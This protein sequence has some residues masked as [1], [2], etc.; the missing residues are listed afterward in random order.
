MPL[1]AFLSGG[2]DSSAIVAMMAQLMDRP[3]KTFSIGFEDES[4]DETPYS[5]VIAER[6]GTE[7]KEFIIKPNALEVL[8]ELISHFG[9]PYGDSS[10]IPTYYL[11]KITRQDVTVALNGDAGDESF[12]GYERYI[13]NKLAQRYQKPVSALTRLFGK[14]INNIPETTDKKD[15]ANRLKRFLNAAGSDKNAGYSRLMAIFNE[16]ERKGLYSDYIRHE[17]ETNRHKNIISDSLKNSDTVDLIDS[18]LFAD[19]MT[20][21]PG[22]LLPKVDITSMANSLEARSPFLDHKFLEFTARIP[23]GFK[24]K[25]LTTKYILR[26]SLKKI[27]PGDILKREKMGF[28]VP[29]G[30]WLK[31]DLKTYAYEV[32]LDSKSVKRG[33]FRKE[34]IKELLDNHMAGKVNNGGKIWVLLNLELWHRMFIDNYTG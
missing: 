14:A 30:K 31:N 7:H 16:E 2:V 26:E 4:F 24:I 25:G 3:V 33:Y 1:G 13:A 5:R 12:G 20:Y 15:A 28:G 17:I 18:M 11:A 9:E 34:K 32:L 21:M 22:D 29:V 23:S 6:F 19:L 10:A 27:L 8:P